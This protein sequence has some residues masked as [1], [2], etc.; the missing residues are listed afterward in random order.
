SSASTISNSRV[1]EPAV[2]S[3]VPVKPDKKA[4]YFVAFFFGLA[5]PV[6]IIVI[7]EYMN[8]KIESRAEVEKLTP[9][10]IIG[11][12]G[13]VSTGEMLVAKPGDRS[14]ISEQFRMIRTN[15]QFVLNK[16][17]RPVILL[18]SSF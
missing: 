1:L 11:E 7:R 2:A 12:I 15:L 17:E 9:V 10:P 3:W 8:D 14:Y 18:T 4:A 6:S 13:H 16:I 5:I